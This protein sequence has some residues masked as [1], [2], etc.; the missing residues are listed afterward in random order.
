MRF[1]SNFCDPMPSAHHMILNICPLGRCKKPN[2][3]QAFGPALR[4]F[5]WCVV[6]QDMY[7]YSPVQRVLR[8]QDGCE[9][10]N[11]SNSLPPARRNL[12]G[13]EIATGGGEGGV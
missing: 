4:I 13:R 10:V 12:C 5:F 11:E 1:Q 7:V 9:N 8:C 3:F 2:R 6:L